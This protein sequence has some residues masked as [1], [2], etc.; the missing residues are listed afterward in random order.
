MSKILIYDNPENFIR[1]ME[2]LQ[3]EYNKRQD[4]ITPRGEFNNSKPAKFIN[5]HNGSK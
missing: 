1:V 2:S 4:T 5:L 3:K